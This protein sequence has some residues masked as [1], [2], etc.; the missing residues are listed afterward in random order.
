MKTHPVAKVSISIILCSAICMF[1]GGCS[2]TS[3]GDERA[4][5]QTAEDLEPEIQARMEYLA[6]RMD[7]LKHMRSLVSLGLTPTQ[8]KRL[9]ATLDDLQKDPQRLK[10]AQKLLTCLRDYEADIRK[11][12][13]AYGDVMTADP[14]EELLPKRK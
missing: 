2:S 4:K 7:D 6:A 12:E 14:A 9:D 13:A 11:D 8:Q 1:V 10:H 5:I 3:R